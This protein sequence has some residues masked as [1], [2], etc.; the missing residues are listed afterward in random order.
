MVYPRYPESVRHGARFRD[1]F[2]N[3]NPI[4]RQKPEEVRP[5]SLIVLESKLALI[6]AGCA[7]RRGFPPSPLGWWLRQRTTIPIHGGQG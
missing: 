4:G 1:T 2:G 7:L 5:Q 6:P 3:P